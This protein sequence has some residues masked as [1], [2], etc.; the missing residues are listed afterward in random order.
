MSHRES[1]RVELMGRVAS[2][3][4]QHAADGLGWN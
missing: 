4:L 1:E 2:E 3:G